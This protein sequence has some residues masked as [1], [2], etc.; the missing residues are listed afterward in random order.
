MFRMSPWSLNST[1]RVNTVSSEH[2]QYEACIYRIMYTPHATKT[3]T[4]YI[5]HSPLH[6]ARETL[7]IAQ[8]V[9][10][11]TFRASFYRGAR[12]QRSSQIFS[13]SVESGKWIDVPTSACL[14]LITSTFGGKRTGEQFLLL[15]IKVAG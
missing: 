5:I 10:K 15:R 4:T 8:N 3:F 12:L 9:L 14:T 6:S 13:N 11:E 2:L 1:D 7:Y